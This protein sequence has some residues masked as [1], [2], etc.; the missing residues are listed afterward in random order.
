M[1]PTQSNVRGKS[2]R[3]TRLKTMVLGPKAVPEGD[4]DVGA[5]GVEY[6]LASQ[7]KE[8]GSIPGT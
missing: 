8:N 2:S 4:E 6:A 5:V 3:E 1:P 7:G